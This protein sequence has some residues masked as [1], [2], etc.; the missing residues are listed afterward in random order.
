MTGWLCGADFGV[1]TIIV[2]VLIGPC[3][4]RLIPLLTP[5]TLRTR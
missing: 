2:V 4:A 3:V 1:G 5:K